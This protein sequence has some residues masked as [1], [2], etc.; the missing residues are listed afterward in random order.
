MREINEFIQI[1]L[2]LQSKAEEDK[3]KDVSG[4][5]IQFCQSDFM[6]K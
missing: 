6:P 1:N 3:R 5:K 4:Q 2:W